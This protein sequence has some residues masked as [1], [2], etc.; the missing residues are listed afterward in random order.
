MCC[1]FASWV[2]SWVLGSCLFWSVSFVGCVF[3]LLLG[4]SFSFS[5]AVFHWGSGLFPC[6]S[7]SRQFGGFFFEY[8]SAFYL[9]KKNNWSLNF[10]ELRPEKKGEEDW[11]HSSCK[12]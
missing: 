4:C 5:V 7:L 3:L 8:V 1:F 2:R 11:L 12:G 10:Q 6:T 9:Y